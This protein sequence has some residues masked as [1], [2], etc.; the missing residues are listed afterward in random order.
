MRRTPPSPPGVPLLGHILAYRRDHLSVF[1]NAYRTLGPVFSL[2]FGPQRLAV[3]VGPEAN[4]FFFTQVDK[5]L[6]LPE[7]NRFVVPMF[8]KVLNAAEDVRVR[9][10]HLAL[11]HSAFHPRRMGR[12]V[13]AMTRETSDWLDGLGE[14][15]TLDLTHCFA[16]LA[17]RIAAAA[18][19]GPEVR[20]RLDDF[21]P[22]LYD[23]ARGMDFV[24]PPNLP[25]PKF[26]RRDRARA[27]LHALIT[28]IIRARRAEPG[29]H[30]DFLQTIVDGGPEGAEPDETVIGLSLLTI[31]TAYIATAAQLTWSLVQL[32]Q[33][34]D[35]RAAVDAER[36]NVF[37]GAAD[38]LDL[39]ALGR[40][41]HLDRALK[42]SQRLHP[43][44]SH[45]ARYNAQGYEYA[46]FDI[47]RGW[48]SVICPAIS[49]RDP[50]IFADPDRYDPERFAPPRAEDKKNPYGLIGFGAG[51]Y[52]CPG[53]TFG[54]NEMKTVISLMLD[55]FDLRLL[56]G[57][58]RPDFEMGVV[59]PAAPC[60]LAYRRRRAGRPAPVA[61]T[62][63]RQPA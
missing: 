14:D 35:T 55:R 48:L 6:S 9:H 44:M 56:D 10:A 12:H 26:R 51:L 60:R 36:R 33:H 28:P 39:D 57:D 20:A 61:A 23:L 27:G 52:R 62:A 47:P 15:G 5:I 7:V 30:D 22:L 54:V 24:L 29:R 18:L 42:E 25:L 16:P 45:Y 8:G 34:P 32:L 1:W 21:V 19:M 58:P 46:G 37:G 63:E 31:F 38:A 4:H 43:V 53:A 59:R 17:M 11:I 2:R 40:L 3:M 41:V 13:D 50:A 49:H